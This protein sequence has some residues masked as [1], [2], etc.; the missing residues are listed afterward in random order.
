[1]NGNIGLRINR[2]KRKD[3][4]WLHEM[5]CSWQQA[6][7][8]LETGYIFKEDHDKWRYHYLEFDKDQQFANVMSQGL[9]NIFKN[10]NDSDEE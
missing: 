1:M 9:S 7:A 4:D 3:S 2:S 10:T 6:A 8:M 5:F